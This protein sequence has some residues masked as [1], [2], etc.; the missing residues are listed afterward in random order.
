MDVYPSEIDVTV[1]ADMSLRR[2]FCDFICGSLLVVLARNEDRAEE[3]V[4]SQ[5]KLRGHKLTLVAATLSQ[6]A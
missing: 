5:S 6:F 1:A 2:L 4:F 3:Q